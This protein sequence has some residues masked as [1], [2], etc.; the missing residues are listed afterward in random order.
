M[1]KEESK[2]AKCSKYV[3]FSWKLDEIQRGIDEF[4]ENFF[5]S[6]VTFFARF[7]SFFSKIYYVTCWMVCNRPYACNSNLFINT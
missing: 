4:A 5:M 6:V 3:I 1:N 2:R 7:D